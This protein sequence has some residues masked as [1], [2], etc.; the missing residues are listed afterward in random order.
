MSKRKKED[1]PEEAEGGWDPAEDP[2]YRKA[3]ELTEQLTDRP[4]F[5]YDPE[6]DPL[7]QGTKTGYLRRA[8]RA[9]A[10]TLGRTSALTGGYASTYAQG[11]AQ[12]AYD[13]ELFRLAELLPDYYDRARSAYE[14]EGKAL[15]DAVG[16]ALGLYDDDYQAFLGRQKQANWE[17]EQDA[18][19]AERD[20]KAE[21][22]EREFA[23]GNDQWERKFSAESDRWERQFAADN[24]QWERQFAAKNEQWAAQ[25]AQ[26]LAEWEQELVQKE[27][28]GQASAAKDER[29]YS[30]RMAMLALQQGLR[31]SDRLLQAAG[32]D[33]DYAETIRRYFAAH[34]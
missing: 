21:Q 34:H 7:W 14:K 11:R 13:E 6:R 30:Y 19:Q 33:K 27:Q 29:S 5:S 8:G 3:G 2:W 26:D 17:R 31:V 12:Q 1:L 18:E 23:A 24:D 25:F 15:Q 32:I 10:D 20:R 16:L 22:W 4:A 9:M 28:S